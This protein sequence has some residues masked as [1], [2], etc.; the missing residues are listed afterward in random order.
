M[1]KSGDI[2]S[3]CLWKEAELEPLVDALNKS[4]QVCLGAPY[5]PF[6]TLWKCILSFFKMI[7][8]GNKF[9]INLG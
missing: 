8:D 4:L 5:Q 7:E 6:K 9:I 1:T 3:Q 2:P